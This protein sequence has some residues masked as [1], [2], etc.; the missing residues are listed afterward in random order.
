MGLALDT[1]LAK[2]TNQVAL[3]GATVAPGNSF[4]VRAFDKPATAKLET[5]FTKAAAA[6]SVRIASPLL[7][8]D[9]EAI[10]FTTAEAPAAYNLPPDIGQPLNSTDALNV[11][12]SS[13]SADSTAVA[14]SIYYSDVTGAQANLKSWGDVAPVI[15]ALHTV[16]VD[17][18]ANATIG[19]WNDTV[20]TTTQND[21]KANRWHALLGYVVDVACLCVAFSGT[22]TSSLRAS[23]PGSTRTEDTSDWFIRQSSHHGTPHIPVFNS[24]N[25][26]TTFVSVADNAASTAV[27]VQLIL[28][29]LS[30][31]YTG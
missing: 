16:E 7:Y 31:A 19:Q 18:T 29:L 12:A 9:T 8:N 24:A 6:H 4:A 30:D 21:L 26:D 5:V 17:V 20:I 28:G 15:E 23:G 27:K 1:V 14:Y 11:Q 2:V 10:Q 22:D 25:K 13:G 3:A